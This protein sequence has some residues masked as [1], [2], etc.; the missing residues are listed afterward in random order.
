M[1]IHPHRLFHDRIWRATLAACGAVSPSRLLSLSECLE[2]GPHPV[3]A[4]LD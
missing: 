4:A 2:L 1:E 3:R